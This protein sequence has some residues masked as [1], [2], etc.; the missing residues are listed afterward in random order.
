MKYFEKFLMQDLSKYYYKKIM[1]LKKKLKLFVEYSKNKTI[2][3]ATP[4]GQ[5]WLMLL[6]LH[7]D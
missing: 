7:L 6:R 3:K 1:F 5:V 2:Q 4:K